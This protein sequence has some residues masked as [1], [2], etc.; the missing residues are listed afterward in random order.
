V[1]T[2]LLQSKL[3]APPLRPDVVARARL[4]SF[5]DITD[6]LKL[7]LV[8]APAGFGKTTVVNDCLIKNADVL[9]P[10]IS[11]DKDDNDEKRFFQQFVTAIAAV[12]DIGKHSLALLDAAQS[13][14][15]DEVLA[16]LLNE[17]TTLTS[18]LCVILDDYHLIQNERIHEAINF[19]LEYAPPAIKLCIISRSDPPLKLAQLRIQA[20]LS[21]LRGDDLR[22]TPQETAD[23]LTNTTNLELTDELSEQLSERAE[24]WAVGLQVM[25]LS[26]SSMT[27]G[28]DQERFLKDLS[29]NNRFLLDYML[30][31][32]LVRQSEEVQ[33]FLLKTSIVDSFNS[34]LCETILTPDDISIAP[35]D[36]IAKLEKANL[37]LNPLDT[38]RQWFRYHQL[39]RD[40]LAHRFASLHPEEVIALRQSA[41]LWYEQ[42][43]EFNEALQQLLKAEQLNDAAD[44]ITRIGPVLIWKQ[45]DASSLMGY[46][47]KLPPQI[48]SL[49]LK[50]LKRSNTYVPKV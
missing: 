38:E 7:I 6:T 31:E 18:P 46:L 13:V 9:S 29:S 17:A 20:Q 25:A 28:S 8:S 22:F 27:E 16:P 32:V 41:A 15:A 12:T 50:I 44:L 45:G 48:Y 43:G 11:L 34:S 33:T 30:D 1:E 24:G 21:E 3:L 37:F 23:F 2:N 47:D 42:H 4:N 40:V 49:V 39:F 10:W 36:M 19:L 5:F 26:L 35:A 14:E